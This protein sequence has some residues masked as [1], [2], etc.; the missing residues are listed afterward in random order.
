M[1]HELLKPL[2]HCSVV[3]LMNKWLFLA[4]FCVSNTYTHCVQFG[5][6]HAYNQMTFEWNVLFDIQQLFLWKGLWGTMYPLKSLIL[7]HSSKWPLL[8]TSIW[9]DTSICTAIIVFTMKCPLE[10]DISHLVHTER[11]QTHNTTSLIWFTNR[12]LFWA[13]FLIE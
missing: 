11:D 4:A 3:R 5:R 2:C 7:K 8:I 13:I 6:A 9:N 1:I 12:W 10:S